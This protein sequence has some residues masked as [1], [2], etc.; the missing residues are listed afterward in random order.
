MGLFDIN[1]AFQPLYDSDKRYFFITGGRGSLKSHSLHD[2]ILKLTYEKGNG[3]LFTRY[4]MT[5]AKKSIIPEFKKTI[6]RLGVEADFHVTEGT[7]INKKTKSFIFFSGIK[8]N[9]GDQTGNLKSLSGINTWVVEEAEDFKDEKVFETIDDSIRTTEKQNRVILVMNPTTPEHFLYDKWFKHTSKQIMIDGFP[10]TVSDHPEVEHIH[11]TFLIGFKYLSKDWLRKAKKW[12]V[13]AKKG[14]DI[15]TG[16]TLTEQEQEKSKLFYVN[17]YLGGWKEK[18]EGCIFDNWEV[19]E[20]DESL[21]YVFGQDYGFDDPTTLIKVAI[22]KK[23]KLLYLD[24]IFYLSGLDD[25]KIFELNMKNCQKSL[26]IG[27]S[28]AKTTIITLQRKKL[29]GKSL[30]II[31]CMKKQGSVLTGIQKMQKYRIIVTNRSKNLIKELNNYVWLDKKSDTPI[32][33]FNHLIDPARYAVDY[34]DR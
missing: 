6:A 23:K 11:T 1:I 32:D 5:S 8:T 27:D 25:D 7:I 28:A 13:R 16:R 24:E 17:N 2:Y 31:P 22:N 30:N 20:F 10:V 14:Y 4:T 12:R 18:Q 26:I 15:V 29:E 9:S 3:V 34:L 21:P 19:G 33:D